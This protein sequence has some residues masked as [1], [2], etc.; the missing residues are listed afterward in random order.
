MAEIKKSSMYLEI[1]EPD[2]TRIDFG[3]PVGNAADA[4]CQQ[5]ETADLM[6]K[7]VGCTHEEAMKA[8]TPTPAPTPTPTRATN[9]SSLDD[10]ISAFAKRLASAVEKACARKRA[11]EKIINSARNRPGL[12]LIRDSEG[13]DRLANSCL[14]HVTEAV[15]SEEK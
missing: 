9:H 5:I 11:I 7:I 8:L 10:A 12:K 13:W 14:A 15:I 4:L 6:E 2:A 1:F 3:T